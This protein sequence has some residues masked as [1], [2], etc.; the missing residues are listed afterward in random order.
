MD[1]RG[2]VPGLAGNPGGVLQQHRAQSFLEYNN[3]ATNWSTGLVVDCPPG[4]APRVNRW[5]EITFHDNWLA[6][7]AGDACC[8]FT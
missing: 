1:H 2:A 6:T 5:I 8:V 7:A 4:L 3:D